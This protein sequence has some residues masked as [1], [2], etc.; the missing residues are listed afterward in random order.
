M[1]T[2]SALTY[3]YPSGK[4]ALHNLSLSI[5]DSAFV[6]VTGVSG[7]GKSTLLRAMNGLVPQFY[8]G[9]FSGSV[10]VDGQS[11][12]QSSPRKMAQAVGFVFQD[13]EAQFVVQTVEDEICFGMEN[14]GVPIDDM[15]RRLD[16]IL[17]TLGIDHLR[18]RQVAT[19][20]GGEAQRVALASALVLRP[21]HLILDEPTSQLDPPAAHNLLDTLVHLNC[22]HRL[23]IM[24]AEHRLERVLN[25]A[26]HLLHL[27]PDLIRFGTVREL[28]PYVPL[29]PPLVQIALDRGWHPIP[30]TVDA[31][32]S[33]LP[34]DSVSPPDPAL[35][36]PPTITNPTITIDNLTIGYASTI[37]LRDFSYSIGRG[38]IVGLLGVNGAGK[39]TLLKSL[40]GLLKPQSGDIHIE[41]RSILG[42]KV[43]DLAQSIGYVPQNPNSVL[44]AETLREE[45]QFTLRNHGLSDDG[46]QFLMRLGLGE[47][48]DHYPRDL[49]GG[50]RQRAALAAMLAAEPPI[51]I[52]DEPTRGLDYVQKQRLA[53]LIREWSAQGKTI[54]IATH[55]VEWIAGLATRCTVLER[56]RI[57]A[58]GK[59]ADVLLTTSGFNTQLG[60]LFSDPDHMTLEAVQ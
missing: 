12:L 31:A 54:L 42:K 8:G 24:L 17:T 40:V 46:T 47:Y 43:A 6:L 13:P 16:D 19:L 57:I 10:L 9:V 2:I 48:L 14:L 5:P 50:E 4:T 59:P 32:R 1:I 41:E 51:I 20:S 58:D 26:T 22:N 25:S 45:V 36:T 7:A 30:L 37:V 3:T 38:E 28:L 11:T 52:L 29:R 15:R 49:S 27:E 23:T 55:D 53:E 56:G 44:F 33:F 21:R 34:P 35:P 60:E 39:S 18:H